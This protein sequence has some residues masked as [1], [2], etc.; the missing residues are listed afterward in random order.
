[1][2]IKAILS[3]STWVS[4]ALI[5]AMLAS[6]LFVSLAVGAENTKLALADRIRM[7]AFERIIL[8]DEYYSRREDRSRILFMSKTEALTAQL[9]HAI[10]L[11]DAAEDLQLLADMREEAQKTMSA[12]RKLAASIQ[13]RAMDVEATSRVTEYERTLY[14]QML[15]NSYLLLDDASRLTDRE[16]KEI[17]SL[18]RLSGGLIA[19]CLVIVAAFILANSLLIG[20][21]LSRGI[22]RL[23]SGA[24]SIG[25][26]DLEYRLPADSDDE[27]AEVSREINRMAGSLAESFT[28]I[29]S[30]REETAERQRAEKESRRALEENENLVAELQHRVKNSFNMIYSMIEL[31]GQEGAAAD[32]RAILGDLAARVRSISELYSLLYSSGSFQEL[33]LDDYCSQVA[34][35]I[36]GLSERITLELDMESVIARPKVAAPIGLILTE[37]VTNTVKYAF[38]GDRR[39]RLRLTLKAAGD[40]ALLELEDDGIGL[41]P[42]FELSGSAG[43]GLHL[44]SALAEQVNGSF[45]MES[46]AAGTRCSVEFALGDMP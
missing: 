12:F 39:G 46:V 8:R 19:A 23:L 21:I 9:E 36:V 16:V 7:T 14:S 20:R 5:L 27:I 43:M 11:F 34:E 37:L 31:A 6:L 44:A 3:I 33:R 41:P 26:G 42:G 30:L 25:G 45:R 22:Q 18:N 38:P 28:S 32:A 15:I 2:R 29:K 40:G 35:S 4:L 24:S 13:G 1:M 17:A 10:L